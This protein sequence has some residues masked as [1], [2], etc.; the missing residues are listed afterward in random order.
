MTLH[1]NLLMIIGLCMVPGAFIVA[2]LLVAIFASQE[3][4]ALVIGE[5][6]GG[7]VFVAGIALFLVGLGMEIR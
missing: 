5:I 7:I 2:I 3:I 6:G 4:G 1:F